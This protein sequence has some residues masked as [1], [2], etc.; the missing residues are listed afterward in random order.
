MSSCPVSSTPDSAGNQRKAAPVGESAAPA[1]EQRDGVWHI[2][3]LPLVRE[4][5]RAGTTTK[6]SG[7]AA[8]VAVQS[9]PLKR[10]PVLY[11]DGPAHKEQ[12]T[13]I[14]RFFAPAV[15]NRDYRDLVTERAEALLARYD[16]AAAHD[17]SETALH[18]STQVAAQVIGLTASH[19]EALARRLTAFFNQPAFMLGEAPTG[20]QRIAAAPAS[21]VAAAKLG[22][23]FLR[24]VRPAIRE[25]RAAMERAAEGGPAAPDDVITYLMGEG[26]TDLEILME[27]LTYGAAGMVTTREFLQMAAWHLLESPELRQAFLEAPSEQRQKILHEILRLE[28]VVGHLYRRTREPL[29]LVDERGTS[30]RIPAGARLKLYVRQANSDPHHVGPDGLQLCPDRELPRG[31]RAEVMAFGDGAHRCPGNS[32]AMLES[33]IFLERLL[34]REVE[35]AGKPRIEWE[36]IV[37][38]YAV[39]GLVLKAPARVPRI[40]DDDGRNQPQCGGPVDAHSPEHSHDHDHEHS[41]NHGD[42]DRFD[43]IAADWDSDPAHIQQSGRVADAIAQAVVLRPG[44]RVLDYGAGTGLVSQAL[45]EREPG[46]QAVVADPSRG[47]REQLMAKVADGRL[48]ADTQVWDVNLDATPLAHSQCAGERFDLVFS[49][50]VLHHVQ[51]MDRVLGDFAAL[52]GDG[53]HVAISEIERPADADLSEP[54]SFAGHHGFLRQEIV[55]RVRAAGLTGVVTTEAGTLTKEGDTFAVFLTVGRS[56]PHP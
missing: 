35:M 1:V 24:D 55:Q 34:S 45:L 28:P 12:R 39:R 25:H 14:A 31:V 50:N 7:F 49:S 41:H 44:M 21:S 43:A 3:S 30:L 29:E 48:P 9:L 52:A 33:E 37:A 56:Q 2:R 32:I 8:E 18:Y 46:L 19:P 13:K 17:L 54:G 20:W 51:N 26:Y 27:C 40:H 11:A 22:W 10:W 36:E 15:V 53:C 5:L 42:Q 16:D 6:Q 38:G 4:V 23:F 47:M